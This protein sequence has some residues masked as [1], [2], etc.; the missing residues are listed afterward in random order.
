MA[1]S[2]GLPHRHLSTAPGAEGLYY[3]IPI[4][5]VI[6]GIIAFFSYRRLHKQIMNGSADHVIGHFL[7]VRK[8]TNITLLLFENYR[9]RSLDYKYSFN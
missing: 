8:I 9:H 3:A 6:L 1:V 5:F 2:A 7:A 4:Y